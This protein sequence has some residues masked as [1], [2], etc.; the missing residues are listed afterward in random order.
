MN[1]LNT[2]AEMLEDYKK[3]YGGCAYAVK[4]LASEKNQDVAERIQG[5]VGE[6]VTVSPNLQAA[7]EIAL[8]RSIQNIISKQGNCQ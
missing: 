2:K 8:G 1:K 3:N 7:I 5:I 6:V 4:K